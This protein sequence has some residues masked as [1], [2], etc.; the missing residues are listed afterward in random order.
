MILWL[1]RRS[2][3]VD[4]TAMNAEKCRIGEIRERDRR[5]KERR[6]S[7]SERDGC[8]ANSTRLLDHLFLFYIRH[9]SATYGATLNH[10]FSFSVP[11]GLFRTILHALRI[12]R[13]LEIGDTQA[14][15]LRQRSL[16]FGENQP[17]RSIHVYSSSDTPP[18]R[19]VLLF[20][21]LLT[22]LFPHGKYDRSHDC[23][24]DISEKLAV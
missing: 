9:W 7:V 14:R 12:L 5:R 21:L 23:S 20:Y 6:I 8:A 1:R 18:T 24:H 19:W 10:H 17:Q 3:N 4:F 15:R 11:H 13:A 22:I 2:F 16:I